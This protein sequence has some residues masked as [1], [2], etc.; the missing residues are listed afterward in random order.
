MA[1]SMH[2]FF[3]VWCASFINLTPERVRAS[4]IGE[5]RSKPYHELE[6]LVSELHAKAWPMVA[7]TCKDCAIDFLSRGALLPWV[8]YVW[9]Q[10][11]TPVTTHYS[12][13]AEDTLPLPPVPSEKKIHV[14]FLSCVDYVLSYDSVES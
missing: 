3:R 12:R 6:C 11:H 2:G 10:P 13:L 5:G 9:P 14:F 1:T 7:C 8:T 4:S